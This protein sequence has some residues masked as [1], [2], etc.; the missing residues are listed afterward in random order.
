MTYRG[1]G[2]NDVDGDGGDAGDDDCSRVVPWE[3]PIPTKQGGLVL[4]DSRVH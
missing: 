2:D 1:D 4:Q 3:G